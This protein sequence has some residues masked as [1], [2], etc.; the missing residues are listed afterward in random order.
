MQEF[1]FT[2]PIPPLLA[3]G[4]LIGIILLV[5]GYR[6]QTDPTR[7]QHLMGLGIVIIGIMIPVSPLS[8]YLYWIV[9]SGLILGIIDIA[10]IAAASIVGIIL[11]YLGFKTYTKSQLEI[12]GPFKR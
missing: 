11:L 3:L 5:L 6:E 4:F 1:M 9:T 7:H 10:I 12:N 2:I 8:W